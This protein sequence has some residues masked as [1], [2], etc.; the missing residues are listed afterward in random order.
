ME[1][2]AVRRNNPETIALWTQ[3]IT[4]CKNSGRHTSEWCSENGI[5]ENCFY[6]RQHRLR[7]RI[8][9]ALPTFVELKPP[10][11]P[12][13]AP[14]LENLNRTATIRIGDIVVDLSNQASAILIKNI[15]EALHAQ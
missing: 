11:E 2:L 5:S 8:G 3:R 7:E 9:S 10:A 6:Y 14:H 1:V 4:D 15:L 13:E 12:Q